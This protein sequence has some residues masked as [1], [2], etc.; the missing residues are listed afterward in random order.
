MKKL[1]IGRLAQLAGVGVA[2]VDRVLNERGGV[3]PETARKVLLAAREHGFNRVLPEA[4]QHPWRIEVILSGNGSFFFKKL[5]NSFSE[6][7]GALGYRRVTLHRTF[8]SESHPVRLAEHIMA[9][10][11]QR[12]GIIV[13]AHDHPA[14]YAALADCRAR[15]IPVITIVTDLPHAERL[16]HVGVNQLQA[17]RTA[18]LLMGRTLKAPGEVVMVSGRSDYSAHRQRIEGFRAVLRQRFP[19]IDLKEVLVGRDER[20]TIR[21]LLTETL[22]KNGHIVGLYNTGSG[23]TEISAELAKHRLLGECV[24]ITHELYSLTRRLL[25]NDSLSYVIDQDARQHAQLAID[26]MLGQLGGGD[27]VDMYQSGKVDFKIF[28]AENCE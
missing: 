3:A 15:D 10:S 21:R 16:C 13:F 14:V 9:C 6:L 20:H 17:G 19:Q 5:D 26:L 11:R 1:T 28:T 27:A 23:N 8:I 18:G 22:N 24:Y 4:Y 25:D 2:T 7:A 12:D